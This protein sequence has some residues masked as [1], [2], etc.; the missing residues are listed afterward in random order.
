MAQ[1]ASRTGAE[2]EDELDEQVRL[3]E[4]KEAKRICSEDLNELITAFVQD[5]PSVERGIFDEELVP[6]E[7][8]QVRMGKIVGEKHPQLSD[9]DQEAVRQHAVAVH[10]ADFGGKDADSVLRELAR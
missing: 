2:E 10:D 6:E 9:E 4:S 5:T 1:T 8:T 7:L 3:S